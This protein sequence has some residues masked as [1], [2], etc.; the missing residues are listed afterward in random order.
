MEL[1]YNGHFG[2]SLF[3]VIFAVISSFRGKNVLAWY[4]WDCKLVL[5]REVFCIV[6]LIQ[7]VL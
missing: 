1:L 7:R 3:R 2:T 6:P 5:N 4:H